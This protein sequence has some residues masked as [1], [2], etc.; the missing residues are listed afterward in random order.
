MRP[1]MFVVALLAVIG[2]TYAQPGLFD[3]DRDRDRDRKPRGERG[4]DPAAMRQ[5]IEDLRKLKLMDVLSLQGEQVETFFG[6]YNPLQKGM[7]D[8]KDAMDAASK[9]LWD[10]T[11]RKAPAAELEKLTSD[12]LARMTT[13][14]RAVNARHDGVRK[15]LTTEQ[16]ARY[17]AFEAR[18]RDELERS[19]LR[20]MRERMQR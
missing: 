5:R 13:F 14:E 11:E 16:F 20:R 3:D 8:A 9:A 15:V 19:I 7:L 18:F 1:T 17:L 2:T 6:T 4:G 12:L 10:A